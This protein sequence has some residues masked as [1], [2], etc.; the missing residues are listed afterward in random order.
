VGQRLQFHVYD[1]EAADRNLQQELTRTRD[2]LKGKEIAGAL[3]ASALGR[4][5][6]LFHVPSHD[7]LAI[8]EAFDGV[9]LGGFFSS[10]EF[11]TLGSRTV[12]QSASASLALFVKKE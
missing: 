10:S 1:P 9:P 7:A 6:E 2:E 11:G 8:N 5:I 4:G 3:I 12:L